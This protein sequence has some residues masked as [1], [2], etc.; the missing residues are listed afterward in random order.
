[1]Y[2]KVKELPECLQSALTNNGYHRPDVELTAKETYALSPNTAFEGSR[3]FTCAVNLE[4]GK[5]ITLH[6]SWGGANPF[7]T[8]IDHDAS[9]RP[10]VANMAVVHGETGGRGS[11]ARVHVAPATLAAMLPAPATELT[12]AQGVVL[13]CLKGYKSAYRRDEAARYGVNS[14]EY[15]TVI[16]E[17]AAKGL[18]KVSSNGATQITTNG[19]NALSGFKLPKPTGW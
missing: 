15:E 16:N 10:I 11:F 14:K 7:E 13:H 18:A 19:K 5:S 1:M 8:T 6:G 9:E 12:P 2:V 4:T 17:L 3:G